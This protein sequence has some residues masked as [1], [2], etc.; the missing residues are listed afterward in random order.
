MLFSRTT[1]LLIRNYFLFFILLS[2]LGCNNNHS[3]SLRFVDTSDSGKEGFLF[4]NILTEDDSINAFKFLYMYNGAGVG[5]ADLNN[6]GLEDV[7][8][9]GN[10]VSSKIFI[11]K[12]EF[13]FEELPSQSG[14]ITNRWVHG[15]SIADI[16][17]DGFKDIYLSVGGVEPAQ[18][19]A[20]L[21][22]INNGDLT[23]TESANTYGLASE[24]LTTQTVFFD[25]DN[26][27]D[28]DA[29][30]LNYENNP[31]KDPNVIRPKRYNGKAIAQDQFFINDNGVF[32]ESTIASG[33]NQEGYGL[34]V[35]VTDFN[36]DGFLDI[37]VSND[38]AYDDF[39]YLNQG[40]GVFEESLK[41]YFNHTSNFGMGLDYAD[42]NNDGNADLLQVDMLPEDNRR[43]K[44]LLSGMNYDR[45]QLSIN[46]G[47]T[48]QYMRNMLQLGNN[49]AKFQDVGNLSGISNTDWSWSPLIADLDNDGLKD[50]F[51]T[52]GYVK[53]VTDVDFRDYI[54]EES[55]N[56][57]ATFDD[58]VVIEALENL[59]GEPTANYLYQNL[60]GLKFQNQSDN[61]GLGTPSFSTGSAYGDL[62]NDGDLDLIVNNL[63]GP[64]FVYENKT[65]ESSANAY[66]QIELTE[67]GN[68]DLVLGSKVKVFSA[69]EIFMAELNPIRGFQSSVQNF[70]H[71]G[72]GTLSSLDSIQIIW[73]DKT[74]SVIENVEINKKHQFDR[75]DHEAQSPSI[76]SPNSDLLFSQ[77]EQS[78]IDFTHEESAF[79]DFKREALLP[80]KLS[81]EG[82]VS[83]VGDINADELDDVFIG[84][85]AGKSSYIQVQQKNGSFNAI[86]LAG[87]MIGEATDALFFDYDND[88]D[89]DLYIVNGSNEFDQNNEA[90]QDLLYTNDGTGRLNLTNHKLPSLSVSGNVVIP[91]DI[92]QDGDLDLFVGGSYLPGRYPMPGKS[93]LL[94]NNNG[95]FKNEIASKAPDLNEIGMIKSAAFAD[96]NGDA[97]NELIITGEFMGI[98]AFQLSNGK[99]SKNE[100]I[101]GLAEEIG[102]W[103]VVVAKDID[104]DG[105]IDL[106]AGNQGLNTRYKASK[107]EPLSVYARDFDGNG[108][109]D[110]ITTFMQK[111]QEYPYA[112]RALF[113]QQINVI[114][115]KFN[116]NL[117]YA[118]ST[119]EGI[120]PRALLDVAYQHK[121]VNM[122]SSIFINQ[123]NGNFE[124]RA[125]PIEAQFSR[126]NDI[127]FVDI[128]NDGL[129]DLLLGGNS[130]A[131]DVFTGNSD[132]QTALLLVN[133]GNATFEPL[134]IQDKGFFKSGVITRLN[135]MRVGNEL[136]ILALRNNDSAGLFTLN[137]GA[138]Q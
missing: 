130:N 137:K 6:D 86:E 77:T 78:V 57:N 10:M 53:D 97:V 52:N 88:G 113:S 30:M 69:G 115:K 72:L 118:E 11:N 121:A 47:Y 31:N 37:Y 15:V 24:S 1:T 46:R 111:G 8:M 124:S 73:P 43:Q 107:D 20:N 70:I 63:N 102:W 112:D 21:L 17:A 71:M 126:V 119:I 25:A 85:A 65:N 13:R 39:L 134:S 44:K 131:P 59:K 94:I 83:E 123:G 23:F 42:V 62:D 99:L 96:L 90:Y 105:D 125:M 117:E 103:N 22:F 28:L 16:N 56:R 68:S 95:I 109:M 120:F 41:S 55:R 128:N 127:L 136:A 50:L 66:I 108:S 4:E 9:A 74:L 3:K 104:Q 89:Q 129:E 133:K 110:A 36:D 14:F 34:G 75:S 116:S 84:A 27:N 45:H 91:L 38:F 67:K 29:F 2:F 98:E 26:D 49:E 54:I 106:V 19:A 101:S 35:H 58:R 64:S 93:Q 12:G 81:T 79:V 61:W 135:Q 60:S 33:I 87:S 32:V 18:Q 80:H 76:L 114:K 7:V 132:A 122:A 51:I 40:N 92:D 82:P 5:I 48:P 138:N 100:S